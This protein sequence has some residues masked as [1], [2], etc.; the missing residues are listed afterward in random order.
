MFLKLLLSLITLLPAI[1]CQPPFL[2]HPIP[3]KAPFFEGY[4]T[5]I[6]SNHTNLV[7][8]VGWVKTPL[9]S[10]LPKNYVSVIY[11]NS[12]VVMKHE[13]WPEEVYLSGKKL[14]VKN[15][16]EFRLEEGK[17]DLE[18]LWNSETFKVNVELGKRVP[19][20]K[21]WVFFFVMRLG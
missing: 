14:Y 21:S 12:S 9:N 8:I 1:I 11:T 18:Y 15:I 4:F 6:N 10:T 2:P 17:F 5:R 20:C 16:G 7:I 13:F 19:W 3:E